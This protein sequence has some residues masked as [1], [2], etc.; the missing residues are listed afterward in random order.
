MHTEHS[1]LPIELNPLCECL[2]TQ[3]G[4]SKD[5]SALLIL[6]A[7][8]VA[9]GDTIQLRTPDAVA[10]SPS[11]PLALVG[12]GISFPRGAVMKLIGPMMEDAEL[13]KTLRDSTGIPAFKLQWEANLRERPEL[14]AAIQLAHAQCEA[15]QTDEQRV[16][17]I[18]RGGITL[19]AMHDQRER[20]RQQI[21]AA[22][23]KL[24]E[25]DEFSDRVQYYLGPEIVV[26]EPCWRDFSKLTSG[27]FDGNPLALCFAH[28]LG[29][30][31]QLSPRERQ[32]CLTA[33]QHA[34]HGK[35]GVTVIACAADGV[36]ADLLWRKELR[37]SGILNPFLF[38]EVGNGVQTDP[39]LVEDRSV[40]EPFHQ[41]LM[42]RFDERVR[43]CKPERRTLLL[44][45]AGLK[46][47]IDLRKW[48]LSEQ[49]DCAP[50]VAPF[51]TVLPD[52]ALQLALGRAVME[53]IPEGIFINGEFVEHAVDF[54]KVIGRRQRIL[55]ERLIMP[56][57]DDETQEAMIEK[58]IRRL[59]A[60]GPLSKRALARTLHNQDYRQIEPMLDTAISLGR[61]EKRGDFYQARNVSVSASAAP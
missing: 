30:I 48:V 59:E 12:D 11:F 7:I 32:D 61:I 34:N 2:A 41:V 20:R 16:S 37:K 26:N 33:L 47:Y 8:G 4:L 22:T 15:E 9:C 45:D 25:I 29:A 38:I 39:T 36:Y 24:A 54:V 56:Q 17:R 10:L 52:I 14:V 31:Q 46:A 27:C 50:E 18:M 44:N 53:G 23:E 60:R 57:T 42:K 40:L 58:V 55:L 28:G 13:T 1:L 21:K 5:T 19:E 35:P 43:G 3:Y 49:R 6:E 51:L